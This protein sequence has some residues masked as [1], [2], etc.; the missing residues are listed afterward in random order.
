VKRL[1]GCILDRG[2]PKPS[3]RRKEACL[4]CT[5]GNNASPNL[6]SIT[7]CMESFI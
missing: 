7:C 6:L 2:R 5:G 4:N 1:A 3:D